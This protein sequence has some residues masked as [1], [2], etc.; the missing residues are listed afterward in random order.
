M[1]NL[2]IFGVIFNFV[3]ILIVFNIF[4]VKYINELEMLN[5][6]IDEGKRIINENKTRF[7]KPIKINFWKLLI[8]YYGL[9]NLVFYSTVIDFKIH[10]EY[11][12]YV[13]FLKNSKDLTSDLQRYL[14]N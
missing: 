14:E 5:I 4:A 11:G 6:S 1:I 8:P 2:L 9:Y 3:G 12:T 7:S 13:S 10:S